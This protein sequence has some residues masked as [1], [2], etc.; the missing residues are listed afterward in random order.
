M[1]KLENSEL[2]E[3]SGGWKWMLSIIPRFVDGVYSFIDGAREANRDLGV[4]PY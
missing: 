2:F 1:K 3:I 4:G